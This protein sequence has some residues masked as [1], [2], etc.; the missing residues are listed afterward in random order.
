[1]DLSQSDYNTVEES[2]EF[3]AEHEFEDG[4]SEIEFE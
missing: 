2:V 1:M 3:E 4:V